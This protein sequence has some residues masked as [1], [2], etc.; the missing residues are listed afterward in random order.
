MD[1]ET[2]ASLIR[3]SQS[4][5]CQI[6]LFRSFLQLTS[7]TSLMTGKYFK[8]IQVD[9]LEVWW[10][11]SLHNP[12]PFSFSLSF[13]VF[14]CMFLL[15]VFPYSSLCCCCSSL[16]LLFLSFSSTELLIGFQCTTHWHPSACRL[17]FERRKKK[18]KISQREIKDSTGKCCMKKKLREKRE[19][20]RC[21]I[22]CHTLSHLNSKSLHAN[23]PLLREVKRKA[24]SKRRKK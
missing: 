15:P 9:P 6:F 12:Q 24:K 2:V 7:D 16:F 13:S 14:L 5:L 10:H 22:H 8:R 23:V 21:T 18:K 19:E 11:D 1:D 3:F 20:T 4:N 17:V